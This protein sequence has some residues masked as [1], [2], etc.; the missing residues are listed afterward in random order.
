MT[1]TIE[2]AESGQILNADKLGRVQVPAEGRESLLEEFER[3]GM[4]GVEFAE[5]HGIKYQ[6]FA[7]WRQSRKKAKASHRGSAPEFYLVETSESQSLETDSGSASELR[8][9]LP[10]GA[11]VKVRSREKV[12]LAMEL[13]RALR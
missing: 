10:G 5:H 8:I 6:T 7:S 1:S 3:S 4:T 13:L 2:P 12:A 9:N 11:R